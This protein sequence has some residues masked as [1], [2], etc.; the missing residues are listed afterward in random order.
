MI[1]STR[2]FYSSNLF[3]FTIFSLGFVIWR[4]GKPLVWDD[5]NAFKHAFESGLIDKSFSFSEL[6]HYHLANF[7]SIISSV[8]P[9]G[10]RPVA[11][12]IQAINL[13]SINSIYPGV[14]HLITIG[15]FIGALAVTF[16]IV[17]S[18]FIKSDFFLLF[19]LII[20]IF[21]AP[22]T[23]ANWISHVGIPSLVPLFS[24]VGFAL[25]F[26][27]LDNPPKKWIYYLFLILTMFFSTLYRE[28]MIILPVTFIALETVRAR[29]LTPIS[30]LSVIICLHSIYPTFLMRI[31]FPE[32]PIKSIFQFG[33]V[34]G[35]LS[36]SI[37]IR[38]QV[39]P[40]FLNIPSPLLLTIGFV[41]FPILFIFQKSN[42]KTMLFTT[43]ASAL[44]VISIMG[45]IFSD[46]WYFY[47]IAIITIFIISFVI[48]VR[49]CIWLAMFLIPF[50]RVYTEQVH[51]TYAMIPFSIL[52]GVLFE[53]CWNINTQNLNLKR[54]IKYTASIAICIGLLDALINIFSVRS[55]MGN[56]SSGIETVSK[57]LQEITSNKPSI[58]ISNAIH[59]DDIRVYLKEKYKIYL[60]VRLGHNRLDRIIDTNELLNDFLSKNLSSSDIY[61]LDVNYDYLPVKKP[62]HE[63]KFVR[64]NNIS[65]IDLDSLHITQ[66]KYLTL[67]PLRQFGNREFFTFLGPP[68]LENDFYRGQSDTPFF[69]KIEADY[70][71]YKLRSPRRFAPGDDGYVIPSPK[72][73]GNLPARNDG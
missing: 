6:I 2:K 49:L 65:T 69:R 25:Y 45:I 43:M 53:G 72:G 9:S 27:I 67:D 7:K 30:I 31:F 50:Y 52:I 40:N 14:W 1:S 64:K 4:Y 37:S 54:G 71:L 33:L 20:F 26:K 12:L 57:K 22:F 3:L 68:D 39:S 35:E 16:R 47:H 60:T 38:T 51:L 41:L 32:L 66:V 55:V 21:C 70:H 63:H 5:T 13:S 11:N 23:A 8:D 48:D 46:R 24:L 15:L 56:I 59:T 36:S 42:L 19:S 61:F 34:G 62:Y 29:K 44:G 10:Y 73:V 58:I 17:A 18:R 28:F